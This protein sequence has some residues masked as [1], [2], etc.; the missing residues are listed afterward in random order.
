[1]VCL[2]ANKRAWSGCKSALD[3]LRWCCLSDGVGETWADCDAGG[4]VG[5]VG[6]EFFRFDD[7]V[8]IIWCAGNAIGEGDAFKRN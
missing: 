5:L 8:T 7:D 1:M 3:G 2:N 6:D 4:E